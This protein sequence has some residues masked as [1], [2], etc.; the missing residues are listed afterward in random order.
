[1]PDDCVAA[2][3]LDQHARGDLAREGA[4]FFPIHILRGNADQ[5][6]FC[7]LHG[8]GNIRERRSDDDIAVFHPRHQRKQRGKKRARLRLILVHLPVAGNYPAAFYSAHLSVSASTPGSLRP[9]R[10]SSEAPP[11]VEMC[12]IC[13]AT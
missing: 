12:E 6:A 4:F 11:P 7:S 9:P 1:M 2:S 10:N 8:G 13:F 3:R 5:A